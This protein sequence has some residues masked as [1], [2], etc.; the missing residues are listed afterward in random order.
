VYLLDI[1]LRW[2]KEGRNKGYAFIDMAIDLG[3]A[4]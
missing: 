1:V 4:K 2:I 3:E